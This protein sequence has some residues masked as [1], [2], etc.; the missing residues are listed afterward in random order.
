M[1]F[2]SSIVR[3][4]PSL[5]SRSLIPPARYA[6]RTSCAWRNLSTTSKTITPAK[7]Q[8]INET[9]LKAN[10]L[11]L[12]DKVKLVLFVPKGDGDGFRELIGKLGGSIIGNFSYC[13][14]TTVGEGRWREMEDGKI[15]PYQDCEQKVEERI[16]TVVPIE[17]ASEL[18]T[19]IRRNHKYKEMGYDIMP[20]LNIRS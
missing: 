1:S 4:T 5:I 2:I 16:E 7:L 13:S 12:S 19:Q 3:H 8:I 10:N 9:L 15:G 6:F 20:L 11:V 17:L 18:I 14:F